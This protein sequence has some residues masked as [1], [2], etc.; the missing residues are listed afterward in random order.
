VRIDFLAWGG[1]PPF[2]AESIGVRTRATKKVDP[3]RAADLTFQLLES[4]V[5]LDAVI[6]IATELSKSIDAKTDHELA[7]ATALFFF[8]QDDLKPSLN[9]TQM[10]ARLTMVQWLQD[11]EIE[12]AEGEYFENQLY[13]LYKP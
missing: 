5:R 13:Q 4:K 6:V 10:M 12:S 1:F 11:G 9:S 8:E 2:V 7:L 3:Q